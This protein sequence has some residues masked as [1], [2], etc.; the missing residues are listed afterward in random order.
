MIEPGRA[1]IGE[2]GATLYSIGAIKQVSIP[3]APFQRLYVA[4]DGGMSDNP[5]PQLYDARYSALIADRAGVHPDRTVTVVGKHCETDVLIWDIPLDDPRP[6]DVLAVQ[7]TGAYNHSMSSNYNRLPRP[8]VVFVHDGQAD[9]VVRRETYADL[10][11][12]EIIP[13]RLMGNEER[14]CD[15]EPAAAPAS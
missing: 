13:E 3:D 6:G 8:A 12:T 1:I 5:R 14:C 9:V 7:C 10:I 15:R 2:A 11:A 4:V